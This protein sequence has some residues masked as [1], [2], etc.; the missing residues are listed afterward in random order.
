MSENEVFALLLLFVAV[1]VLRSLA[2]RRDERS[3]PLLLLVPLFSL[4]SHAS[5]PVPPPIAD[6]ESPTRM[7]RLAVSSLLS[8]P[9]FGIVFFTDIYL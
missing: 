4:D 9:R 5:P 3:S 2:L 7:L 8:R 6:E 1:D